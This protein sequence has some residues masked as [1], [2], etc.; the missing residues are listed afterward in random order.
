VA[1]WRGRLERATTDRRMRHGAMIVGALVLLAIIV[2]PTLKAYIGQKQQ[3]SALREQVTAQE[4]VVDELKAEQARWQD[5]AYVEQQAR[6]RLKFVKVGEK[7]YTVL[8]PEDTQAI[9]PGMAQAS[10]DSAWYATIWS[11]LE[12]A[13]APAAAK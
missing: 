12:A 7:A 13:D 5:P 4:K 11:S 2:G 1:G 10:K 9:A 3:I 6:Q 8:D